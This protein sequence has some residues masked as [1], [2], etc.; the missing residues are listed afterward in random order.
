MNINSILGLVTFVGL[1]MVIGGIALAAN[2]VANRRKAQPGIV[3]ALIGVLVTVLFFIFSSGIVQVDST[4]VAVVYQPFSG[5]PSVGRLSK[6]PLGPGV[7]VVIPYLNVATIY[8]TRLQS[9]TMSGV[10]SEGQ[11]RGDD[12]IKART[13]DGQQ[14]DLDVSILYGISRANVNQL[15]LKW[16]TRYQD[17]FVRPISRE[18][19][20]E[21]VSA[22][23]VE[24]IYGE[25]RAELKVKIFASIKPKFEENGLEIS[26][27]LVRNVTFSAEYIKA[28]EQKQVAAQD[29][30]RAKQEADRVRTQAKGQADAVV[31]SAEG[32]SKALAARVQG[33]AEAIRVRAKAEADALGLINEQLVKNP[34]L[35]QYTYVQKL[36]DKVSIM[37]VPSGSPFLFNLDNLAGGMATPGTTVTAPT[38]TPAP[39]PKP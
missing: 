1:L 2:N 19:V 9:Y 28:I 5:D 17:E 23:G 26:D 27:V 24:E 35:I 29:A 4:E 3:I 21:A 20:R 15:H 30:E 34:L 14:V 37:L 31:L 39:T 7:H 22:Y 8:S 25:K 13:K 11:L 36:S 38:Q 12:S 18:A 33:E 32:E 6:E 16:Q 10:T